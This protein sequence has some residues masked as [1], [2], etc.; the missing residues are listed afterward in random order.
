MQRA[1]FTIAV[2]FELIVMSFLRF[3]I[4]FSI[5]IHITNTL[6][7]Y[8]KYQHSMCNLFSEHVTVACIC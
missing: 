3:I 4:L 5:G 6:Y 8:S 1:G 7:P 2:D